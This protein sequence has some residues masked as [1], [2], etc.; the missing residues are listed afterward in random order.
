MRI[1]LLP[2]MLVGSICLVSMAI[3]VMGARSEE[4]ERFL[5]P[6]LVGFV[7]AATTYSFIATFCTIPEKAD[8]SQRLI[9]KLKRRIS[10]GWYWFIAVVFLGT[11]V[12]AL[13]LTGR[14]MSIWLKDYVN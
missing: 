14:L 3:I 1:L 5:T 13:I 12:A 8:N 2:S 7:W 6:S 9:G 11:T 10:R 4:F